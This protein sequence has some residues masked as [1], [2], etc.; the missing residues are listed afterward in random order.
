MRTAGVEERR[1]P[2]WRYAVFITGNLLFVFAAV[3]GAAM[4]VASNDHWIGS[5]M[6]SVVVN[7]IG[8]PLHIRKYGPVW[9]WL[10]PIWTTT[11]RR[12]VWIQW[13]TREGRKHDPG[14]VVSRASRHSVTAR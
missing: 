6:V 13:R 10:A 12:W 5:M 1:H 3:H 2:A 9:I 14:T 4:A 8:L 7:A 11:L